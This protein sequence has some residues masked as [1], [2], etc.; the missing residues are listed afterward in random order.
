ME[1][2][3]KSIL[4]AGLLGATLAAFGCDR[5]KT[6][7]RRNEE[8]AAADNTKRNERDDK[9]GALTPGDQ[10]ESESD[11][12]ITQKVRQ[13]VVGHDE[14][15]TNATNVKII[16]RDSVVTLRGPVDSQKEK[17]AVETIARQVEGV[18]RVE[19][20]LEIAAK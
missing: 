13:G 9:A 8:P 11:R 19:N 5:S 6:E 18:K 7:E 1:Q 14:L 16:T 4:I 2:R 3:M 10:G 17:T 20:Q 15:S 12:T